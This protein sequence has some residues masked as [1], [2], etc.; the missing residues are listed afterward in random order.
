MDIDR[1]QIDDAVL[2]LLFLGRHDE[3]RT[4]RSFDWAAMERLHTK[5]LISD[6]VGKA[7]SVVFTDE[8]LRQSEA[9]FRKLF[10]LRR[11]A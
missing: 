1:D 6:P 9:L 7:N 2:A 4:W 10:T 3:T 8:G 11:E 5:G